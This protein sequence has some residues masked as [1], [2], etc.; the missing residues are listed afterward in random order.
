VVGDKVVIKHCTPLSTLK[1]YYVRN[2]VKP[3]PRETYY[4]EN[5][6]KKVMS[7]ALKSE[8]AK[9]YKDFLSKETKIADVKNKKEE[10]AIKSALKAKALTRAMVNVRK[11]ENNLKK[12]DS[13]NRSKSADSAKTPSAS[14]TLATAAS[15][16][17][18]KEL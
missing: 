5:E 10:V 18:S 11:A 3:F 15:Q 13:K 16:K 12:R 6:E 2:I 1:H 17:L 8:Y 7:E 14:P 4:E 9:L